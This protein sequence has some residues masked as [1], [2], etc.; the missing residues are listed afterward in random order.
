MFQEVNH[1]RPCFSAAVFLV[2]F[3]LIQGFPPPF[4]F[5]GRPGPLSRAN[6]RSGRIGTRT[7]M[8]SC[9]VLVVHQVAWLAC[10]VQESRFIEPEIV[11]GPHEKATAREG[12]ESLVLSLPLCPPPWGYYRDL[13]LFRPLTPRPAA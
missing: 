7:G 9:L 6:E 4:L 3:L 8:F 10:V 11:F 13:P 5:F 1:S 12:D 2:F